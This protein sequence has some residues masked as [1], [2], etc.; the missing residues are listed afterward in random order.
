MSDIVEEDQVVKEDSGHHAN[1]RKGWNV[2]KVEVK[3]REILAIIPCI[4]LNSV[5]K[6]HNPT[7]INLSGVYKV[8]HL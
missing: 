4:R 1:S 5:C 7:N 8:Y 3:C 2:K 6:S